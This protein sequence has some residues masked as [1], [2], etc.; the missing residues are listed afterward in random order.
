MRIHQEACQQ[1]M[2]ELKT[3]LH[4]RRR[5]DLHNIIKATVEEAVALSLQDGRSV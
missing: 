2:K 1:I 4:K 5:G 3:T